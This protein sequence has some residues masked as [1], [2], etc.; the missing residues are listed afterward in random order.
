V[1]WGTEKNPQ[2]V[3]FISSAGHPRLGEKLQKYNQPGQKTHKTVERER[4]QSK[5]RK[6][7]T[8]TLSRKLNRP[9]LVKAQQEK[10]K[11]KTEKGDQQIPPQQSF[12][13]HPVKTEGPN[14]RIP[15]Q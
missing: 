15:A 10:R 5:E 7:P 2:G 8:A 3:E 14:N 9:L 6:L 11:L 13:L 1:F 4:P 12:L